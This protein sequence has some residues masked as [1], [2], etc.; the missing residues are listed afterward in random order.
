[1]QFG[2]SWLLRCLAFTVGLIITVWATTA[3]SLP[4]LPFLP[5]L[6]Y[7]TSGLGLAQDVK[8]DL[9]LQVHP[10]PPTLAQWQDAQATGDYFDQIQP[11]N[12][13]YL[14]W[15]EFPVKVF[16]Q[17]VEFGSTSPSLIQ[18][19][20]AWVA[21]VSQ[22]VK[23][24]NLYLPLT[25]VEQAEA[26]DIIIWRSTPPLRLGTEPPNSQQPGRQATR[27]QIRARN[28][29]TRYEIY[30]K[31]VPARGKLPATIALAHRF[32]IYLRPDQPVPYTLAT[33][34]HE[35]GHALGIWGHSLQPTD[36]LYASQVR[37]PPTIS[38]RD[39]N[40]LKRVYEQ[41]TRLGWQISR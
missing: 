32:T 17:P 6:H 13:G 35:L 21:A 18:R 15:S 22:A 12:V 19:S 10:L 31:Q 23:E 1:M 41:P 24:W 20:Q 27:F 11:V 14:V 28:A 2:R 8:D 37:Q 36:A 39:I 4:P 25:I 26:A 29:E 9:P 33:A 3:I 38:A 40:T 7:R 34:R 5:W 30:V 16:V